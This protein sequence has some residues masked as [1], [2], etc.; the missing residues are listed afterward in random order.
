MPERSFNLYH[1]IL[2]DSYN[3]YTKFISRRV[4]ERGRLFTMIARREIKFNNEFDLIHD[5]R[6]H[7]FLARR[8]FLKNLSLI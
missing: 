5:L 3:G 6:D 1:R 2:S 8:S 7:P 4:I